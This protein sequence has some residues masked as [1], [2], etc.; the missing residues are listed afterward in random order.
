[1][2]I[3][4]ERVVGELPPLTLIQVE[5]EAQ[6]DPAF[7]NYFSPLALSP[8]GAIA[9]DEDMKRA[10]IHLLDPARF[11]EVQGRWPMFVDTIQRLLGVARVATGS[12]QRPLLWPHFSGMVGLGQTGGANVFDALGSAVNMFG[13]YYSA[14][15]NAK[16]EAARRRHEMRL[17]TMMVEAEERAAKREAEAQRLAAERAIAAARQSTPA[18]AG[19][20]WG[21]YALVAAGTGAAL[22]A[23]SS[24]L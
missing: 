20:S 22:Y 16:L 4:L 13:Q 19:T 7:W 17:Q 23:G 6:H 5:E 8:G 9:I 18:E 1:M 21:T 12:G 11:P 24:I 15:L 3:A 10:V 14:K 2:T